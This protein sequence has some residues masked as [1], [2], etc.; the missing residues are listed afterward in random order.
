MPHKQWLQFLR[1]TYIYIYYIYIYII[2]IPGIY[3][4]RA[5]WLMSPTTMVDL[6]F[7][8]HG[9]LITRPARCTMSSS[10]PPSPSDRT[11]DF[12]GSLSCTQ[13]GSHVVGDRRRSSSRRRSLGGRPD[14]ME[15][16]R[17]HRKHRKV[18]HLHSPDARGG[19]IA[20]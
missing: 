10:P 1:A 8:W 9:W 12:D 7:D 13:L 20:W 19:G 17:W 18:P 4:Q 6:V 15:R 11:N 3:I 2:Y 14:G 5:R 16:T